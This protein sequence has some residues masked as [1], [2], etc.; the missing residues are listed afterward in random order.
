MNFKSEI[1][2]FLCNWAGYPAVDLA[3]I[4]R[5]K[6]SPC[7]RIIRVMRSGRVDTTFVLKAFRECADRVLILWLS[8]W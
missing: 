6:Y 5:K 7:I 8:S 1:S 2:T 3:G 4:T